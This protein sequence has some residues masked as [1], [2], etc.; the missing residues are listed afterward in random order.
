MPGVHYIQIGKDYESDPKT[1][2]YF[3]SEQEL[4]GITYKM[5]INKSVR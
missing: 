5:F 1:S 3:V 4:K 2:N